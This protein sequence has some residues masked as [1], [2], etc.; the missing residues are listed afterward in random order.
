MY[1]FP[2]AIFTLVTVSAV[3]VWFIIIRNAQATLEAFRWV[4][5]SELWISVTSVF[6]VAIVLS[7]IPTVISAR[8]YLRV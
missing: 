4:G 7:I 8:R 6:A 3:G 5:M 1:K 2:P